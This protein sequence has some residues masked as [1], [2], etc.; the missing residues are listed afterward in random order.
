MQ[1]HGA[2]PLGLAVILMD[3]AAM[4]KAGGSCGRWRSERCEADDGVQRTAD[5]LCALQ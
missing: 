2:L 5:N 3:T 4:G 1:G